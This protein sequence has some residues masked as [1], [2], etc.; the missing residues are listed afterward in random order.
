M[1][2]LSL[3]F[4]PVVIKTQAQAQASTVSDKVKNRLEQLD[5]FEEVTPTLEINKK[6]KKWICLAYTFLKWVW[7]IRGKL[8]VYGSQKATFVIK[9][10]FQ[11]NNWIT[12]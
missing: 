3:F 9:L 11:N 8:Y 12:D 6:K 7:N 10:L 4:A 1:D 2:L 5:D